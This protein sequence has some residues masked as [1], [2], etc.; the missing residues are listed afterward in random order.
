VSPKKIGPRPK[1]PDA[2]LL[3]VATHAEVCQISD[4]DLRGKDVKR[5]IGASIISTRHEGGAFG[6]EAVWRKVRKEHPYLFQAAC[7]MSVDDARA[8]WT[9]YFNL[10]QWF[11]DAKK[12]L[13]LTGRVADEEVFDD[14]GRL[15]SQVC[16]KK[17]TER[18]IINMDETNHDLSMTGD[19]SGSRA[20]SY[21]NPAYQRGTNRSFKSA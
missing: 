17:D 11:D 19:K 4:G 12:D 9:T 5:L 20:L 21:H 1:I 16:F 14:E 13:I 2:F 7:K 15:V 18:R 10:D 8:Q 6:V 3:A